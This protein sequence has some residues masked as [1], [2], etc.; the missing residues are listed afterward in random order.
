MKVQVLYVRQGQDRSGAAEIK[1]IFIIFIAAASFA[2][3]ASP[4]TASSSEIV[5]CGAP[6]HLQRTLQPG[7]NVTAL[8][9]RGRGGWSWQSRQKARPGNLYC[10]TVQQWAVQWV[11]KMKCSGDTGLG[12]E[13]VS[14]AWDYCL[15]YH[16][17]MT[18]DCSV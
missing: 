1:T 9:G 17:I 3:L 4:V 15:F 11:K 14:L 10:M 16:Q 18:T 2:F 8:H 5:S 12:I 7:C 13:A 6:A